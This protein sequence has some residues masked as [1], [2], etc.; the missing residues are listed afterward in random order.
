[1]IENKL[2]ELKD[3][4]STDLKNL[5]NQIK[6]ESDKF[7]EESSDHIK[8]LLQLVNS[9]MFETSGLYKNL[10]KANQNVSNQQK[11]K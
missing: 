6:E 1:L 11:F 3:L 4:V 2:Y 7:N 8:K 10:S 9:A 5:L